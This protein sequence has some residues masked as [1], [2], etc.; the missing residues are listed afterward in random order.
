MF[1]EIPEFIETN[2]L[3]MDLKDVLK[4]LKQLEERFRNCNLSSQSAIKSHWINCVNP[5]ASQQELDASFQLIVSHAEDA[6]AVHHELIALSDRI[7][8]GIVDEDPTDISQKIKENLPNTLS[9]LIRK[10]SDLS[11]HIFTIQGSMDKVALEA[12]VIRSKLAEIF[13][14][15]TPNST[16]QLI[17]AG[18]STDG[19][20]E[21]PGVGF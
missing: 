11:L 18:A 12:R 4:E 7:N 10:A 8:E 9:D 1:K 2:D 17:F 5:E 6:K 15:S 21:G 3:P 16:E 13:A 14:I 20:D 19:G